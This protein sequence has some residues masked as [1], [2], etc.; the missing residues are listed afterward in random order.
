MNKNNDFLRYYTP[1]I[2]DK[3]EIYGMTD[4]LIF[5]S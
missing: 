2:A 1:I 4:S 3:I 5:K